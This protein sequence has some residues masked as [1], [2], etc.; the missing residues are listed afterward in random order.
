MEFREIIKEDI[1]FLE[2]PNWVLDS[3]T[4]LKRLFIDKSNGIYEVISPEGMPTHFDKIVIYCVQYLLL[5]KTSLASRELITSRYEIARN[6]FKGKITGAYKFERI[7]KSLKKWKALYINFK[8]IFYEGDN[9]TERVFSVIDD[10]IHNPATKVLTIRFNEQYLLH[11]KETKFYRY[12]DFADYKRLTKAISARLYELLI[13]SFKQR[14]SWPI[15]ICNL[16]EKLTLEK[17]AKAKEYYPSDVLIKL[18]PAIAEINDK[19]ELKISLDYKKDNNLCIFRSIRSSERVNN[20]PKLTHDKDMSQETQSL[21]GILLTYGISKAKAIELINIYSESK[22]KHKIELLRQSNQ[23]IKNVTAWLIKSLQ[24]DWN[25]QAYNKQLEEKSIK[26]EKARKQKEQEELKK[27]IEI[28]KGEFAEYK[29]AKAREI[30]DTLPDLL[31]ENLSDQFVLWLKAYGTGPNDE[32]SCRN[33][34]LASILL[35]K[36]EQSFEKWLATTQRT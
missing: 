21:V 14:D 29:G 22:V 6:I 32:E 9:Y 4:K 27:K 5:S 35:K 25:V 10:I 26:E 24:E 7:V 8:G 28:L 12:I 11:L 36:D 33:A 2:Y 13:K 17:R 16:A 15:N 31:Q 3:R 34:F 20:P 18:K 1:N 23:A 30:F 19:T